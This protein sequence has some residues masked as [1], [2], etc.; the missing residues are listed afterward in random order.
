M[1][2]LVTRRFLACCACDALGFETTVDIE[3]AGEQFS[4]RGLMVRELNYLKER[5]TLSETLPRHFLLDPLP[6]HR[7]V[8]H[9][10]TTRPRHVRNVSAT[11][12]PGVEV[13]AVEREED[14]ELL[15]RGAV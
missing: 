3:M 11:R 12:P 13:G 7:R 5:P 1:Y 9:T 4:S 6:S 2:E 15:P 14:P 8:R 10:R